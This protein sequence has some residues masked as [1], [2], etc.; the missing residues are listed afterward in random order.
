MPPKGSR[1]GGKPGNRGGKGFHLAARSGSHAYKGRAQKI[2]DQLVH[3][4]KVKKDYYKQLSKED[5]S[6]ETP[7]YVKEIFGERT[8]DED[9][10]IVEYGASSTK[11]KREDGDE[12]VHDLDEQSSSSE[13]DGS[14]S[15]AGDSTRNRRNKGS[16]PNPFK[17]EVLKQKDTKEVQQ[18][19]LEQKKKEKEEQQKGR[20]KYYKQ[21]KEVRGKMMARNARGQPKMG[22]QINLLLDKIQHDFA[23]DN[24]REKK[25]LKRMEKRNTDNTNEGQDADDNE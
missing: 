19:E 23:K 1:G 12:K 11:R 7:D 16:K 9:G 14:D 22:T 2:K 20:A 18:Q 15:D 24:K 10:N 8:I 13:D 6:L 3:K 17:K 4:A 5:S 25:R 21:R